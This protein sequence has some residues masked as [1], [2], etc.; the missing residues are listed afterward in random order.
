MIGHHTRAHGGRPT[1]PP[2]EYK[3]YRA[4]PRLL[5]ARRAT[6]ARCSTSCAARAAR[7]ERQAPAPITVGRVRQVAGR[8]RSVAWLALSLVALPRSSAQVN[9]DQ[10][11]DAA[12]G[13]ARRR[14]RRARSSPQTTLVLGSDQRTEGTKEPGAS[15]SGPSRSD[16]IL[17]LR[18]GG[19]H[20]AKLSIPRDT[21]VDIPGHGRNKINAAYAIGGAALTIQTIKQY[22]GID[23]QPRLR[24]Q[25]RRTS[26]TS[27]TRWAAST[28]PAAASSRASTAASRTAA[29]RCACAAGTTHIDGKQALALARTRHNDVQPARG[30]PHPRAPPAEDPQRDEAPRVLARRASSACRLISWNAPKTVKTDMGGP[31]LLGYALGDARSAATRRPRCSSPGRRDAARRR[32]RP[33]RLGRREAGRGPALPAPA[34]P[35][36]STRTAFG[37]GLLR[38]ALASPTTTRTRT[39]MSLS[40]ALD[41]VLSAPSLAE[42]SSSRLRRF[43][44]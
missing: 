41:S 7:R 14:R 24:G 6:T 4:R 38:L 28:T 42:R 22:L 20:S 8:S 32:R 29:S 19:G 17:L 26:P 21:V 13:A 18:F 23:D 10:V 5:A 37:V 11:S 40:L 12:A 31:T 33:R 27:S 25:L 39:T 44:P 43:V 16:T 9:Q 2:P 1:R 3:L 35:V 30:R 36:R 15:T 34:S